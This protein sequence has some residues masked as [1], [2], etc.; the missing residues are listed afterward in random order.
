MSDKESESVTTVPSDEHNVEEHLKRKA[1]HISNDIELE[2]KTAVTAIPENGAGKEVKRARPDNNKIPSVFGTKPVND[3]VQYVSNFLWRHCDQPHIET[4]E[5]TSE[6]I[7]L[8]GQKQAILIPD[9]SIRIRFQSDMSLSQHK[10]YNVMLNELVQKP[11]GGER[12]KYKHTRERDRFYKLPYGRKIRVTTDQQT[13]EI[14]P[15]GV[16]E[17]TRVADINIYS[18]N[19]AFD[20]RISVSLESPGLYHVFVDLSTKPRPMLISVTQ[21][22]ASIPEGSHMFER[23][24]D[25]LSYS[26]GNIQFDL[27]QVKSPDSIGQQ[28]VTHELELEFIDASILAAE[29]RKQAQGEASEFANMIEVFLDNAR[30]LSKR[31]GRA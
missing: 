20:Y 17:K 28:D 11:P 4:Q 14:V 31:G 1:E 3:L 18:P 21:N 7:C 25:R 19:Q 9:N 12:V 13:G 30:M 10:Q 2:N 26:Q 15:N 16:L 24:K 22:A 23:N 8:L 27:T 5:Q 6:F 29:K